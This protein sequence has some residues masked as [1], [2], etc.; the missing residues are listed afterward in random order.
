[1]SKDIIERAV[2]KGAGGAESGNVEEVRY[3]GYGP[4]AIIVDCMT[5]NR[6]RTC[7]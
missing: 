5:D 4:V 1:M 6:N 2:V 3:E 7:W